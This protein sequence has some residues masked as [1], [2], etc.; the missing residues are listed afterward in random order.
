MNQLNGPA[1]RR[2]LIGAVLIGLFLAV[3]GAFGTINVPFFYR[4]GVM[5]VIALIGA[6]TGMVA[7]ALAG[8]I[9][10]LD[11]RPPQGA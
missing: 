4:A 1:V 7:Y 5:I 9:T 8:R 3:V 10:G 6:G 11:D 2:T